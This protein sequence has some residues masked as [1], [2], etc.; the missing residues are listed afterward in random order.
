MVEEMILELR[1]DRII[2]RGDDA[3]L[4]STQFSRQTSNTFSLW[5][6]SNCRKTDPFLLISQT[7]VVVFLKLYLRIL[8]YRVLRLIC[9]CLAASCLFQLVS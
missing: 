2:V 4:N 5:A 3:V 8:L 7:D 6:F 9:N 1:L